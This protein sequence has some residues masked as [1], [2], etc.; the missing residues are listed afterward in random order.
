MQHTYFVSVLIV[1][2]TY[3]H[4]E[5]NPDVSYTTYRLEN[6]YIGDIAGCEDCL[7]MQVTPVILDNY[8]SRIDGVQ[9]ITDLT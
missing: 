7:I 6:Q 4:I 8:K 3:M 1:F 2:G 9:V 5:A